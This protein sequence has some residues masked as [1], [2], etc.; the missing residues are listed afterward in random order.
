VTGARIAV[1]TG[2]TS[3]IGLACAEGLATRGYQV[4]IVGRDADR[5]RAASG[6][7][8]GR[9]V[10]ADCSEPDGA[11]LVVD[12]LER[13]DLLVHSAGILQGAPMRDQDL[14]VF[15]RVMKVNVRGA[16]LTA[17]AVLP[18]MEPGGRMIFISSTAGRRGQ[19]GLTAYSASKAA[20]SAMAEALAAEVER[21]GINV[22]IVTPAPVQTRMVTEALDQT[23]T[24]DP[25][26]V[27]DAV[28]WLEALNPRVV[29]RDIVM[30]AAL[31]GPFAD[32]GA[33]RVAG[34]P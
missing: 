27:A 19:R 26:D 15:D 33:A 32:P 17:A 29:V 7:T 16:Y 14:S 34:L 6:R 25:S 18:L 22:H 5:A 2:G 31:E 28:L 13:I 23:F 9:W 4:T 11:A 10:A 30:R 20:L 3:G 21:E 1:V 12:G 24:L 8:G